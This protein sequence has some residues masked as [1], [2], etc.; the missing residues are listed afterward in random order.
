MNVLIA[1]FNEQLEL[2]D[3]TIPILG[4]DP[5]PFEANVDRLSERLDEM[6][7]EVDDEH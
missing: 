3:E 5:K 2:V 6:Q 1:A 4:W 7:K